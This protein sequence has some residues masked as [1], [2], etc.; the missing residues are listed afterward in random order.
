MIIVRNTAGKCSRCAAYRRTLLLAAG[1]GARAP[2][3][4]TAI[5]DARCHISNARRLRLRGSFC[6]AGPAALLPA[7]EA[8]LRG[9]CRRRGRVQP[10]RAPAPDHKARRRRLRLRPGC[11]TAGI[12]GT[13][14]RLS[15]AQMM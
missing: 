1:D 4:A 11:H 9:G 13:V 12:C 14:W 7:P 3:G 8:R 2:R 15:Q 6:G 10:R 5:D